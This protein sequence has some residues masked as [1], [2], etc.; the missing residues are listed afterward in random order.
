MA[1]L[2]NRVYIASKLGP[3]EEMVQRLRDELVGRGYIIIYDWTER[4]VQRPFAEHAD[5]AHE[6]AEAMAEAVRCCDI[7]IVLCAPNGLGMHIETGGALVTSIILSFITKQEQKKIY[8]IGEGN[9]RSVFYFHRSV[10]RL[11]S[12]K[13]LLEMLPCVS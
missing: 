8:V 12:T 4:P 3:M 13:T 5:E 6:A 11:P 2:K 9:E 10:T 1:E 7:L